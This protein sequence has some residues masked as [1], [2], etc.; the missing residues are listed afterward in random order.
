MC[1][2]TRGR[3]FQSSEALEATP[4]PMP[5]FPIARVGADASLLSA[6]SDDFMMMATSQI[7][8]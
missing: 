5:D 3:Q 7:V 8:G 6:L 1:H 4:G 2:A